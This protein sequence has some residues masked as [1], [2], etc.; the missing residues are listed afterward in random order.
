MTNLD[1]TMSIFNVISYFFRPSN[2]IEELNLY[3]PF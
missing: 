1:L 3:S 2:F